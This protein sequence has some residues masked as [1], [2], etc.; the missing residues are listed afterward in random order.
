M[1]EKPIISFSLSGS[2][3][4]P[5]SQMRVEAGQAIVGAF[6]TF[7]AVFCVAMFLSW[8]PTAN[9]SFSNIGLARLIFSLPPA[10][11]L[12]LLVFK[13][14]CKPRNHLR[15]F[16]GRK[17]DNSTDSAKHLNYEMKEIIKL[18]GAQGIEI[19][20]NVP[21]SLSQEAQGFFVIGAP[22][23]GKTVA[24]KHLMMQAVKRGDKCVIFD[25][26]G[27]F[28][29]MLLSQKI[30]LFYFAPWH[31]NTNAI[32]FCADLK[33]EF[34]A[35]E[36][37]NRIIPKPTQGSP[38]WALGAQTMLIGLIVSLQNSGYWNLTDL[39]NLINL[40]TQ[41]MREIL[42]NAYLQGA[43]IIATDGV[44]TECYMSML[45]TSCAP[46]NFL[47]TAFKNVKKESTA[48][49][50]R[51][52]IS[53]NPDR[54]ILIIGGS[55]EYGTLMEICAKFVVTTIAN[56]VGGLP[57]SKSRKLWFFLDEFPQIGRLDDIKRLVE[58]GRSKGLRVVIGTQDIAQIEGLYNRESATA[59]QAML[60]TKIICGVSG[61]VT[62]DSISKSLGVQTVERP[63]VSINYNA[64]GKSTSTSWQKETMPLVPVSVLTAGLGKDKTG[65]YALVDI[66]NTQTIYKI[67]W[68]F[69]NYKKIEKIGK[70]ADKIDA[71]KAKEF[72]QIALKTETEKANFFALQTQPTI[73]HV[74]SL[75]ILSETALTKSDATQQKTLKNETVVTDSQATIKIEDADALKEMSTSVAITA[76]A[77]S[78]VLHIVDAISIVAESFKTPLNNNEAHIKNNTKKSALERLNELEGEM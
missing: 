15:Y 52:A 65:I 50:V 8:K 49:L 41:N 17:F 12:S 66:R 74:K 72:A 51:W 20:P 62:A 47:A 77:G 1:N 71:I 2:P 5:P 60:A 18:D 48:S 31:S 24:I 19:C 13:S 54:K 37:A 25:P 22:G 70:I 56:K 75:P 3:N 30:P 45:R 7:I 53:D 10:F 64:Q 28:L 38:N 42:Q 29:E 16:E 44:S 23:G 69:V 57:D 59:L 26:K 6:A 33:T 36:F 39:A 11:I 73:Q 61:G 35:L 27:D 78:E 4:L 14:A 46:I 43:A 32:D 58:F 67:K 21:I 40:P 55:K 34:D 68:P 9:S 63:N 76:L